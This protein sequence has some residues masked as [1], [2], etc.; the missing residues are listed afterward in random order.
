VGRRSYRQDLTVVTYQ[1]RPAATR[2]DLQN[3][4]QR[5]GTVNATT[6]S[7]YSG[8]PQISLRPRSLRISSADGSQSRSAPWAS[9]VRVGRFESA[10]K[11]THISGG[12]KLP[13][14]AAAGA[15]FAGILAEA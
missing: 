5:E 11:K 2:Q 15:L 14:S 3:H 6:G 12:L 8:S 10:T 1:S 13:Q 4:T 9:R 7:T